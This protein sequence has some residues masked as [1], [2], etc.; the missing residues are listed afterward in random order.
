MDGKDFKILMNDLYPQMLR[1]AEMVLGDADAAAD[2]VQDVAIRLWQH[3]RDLETADNRRAYCLRSVRN[4][5]LSTM[6]TLS[7]PEPLEAAAEIA[8]SPPYSDTASA[9]LT[10]LEHLPDQQRQ[11]FMLR[12][13]DGLEF[14]TIADRMNLSSANARQLLSRARKKLQTLCKQH[15]I[16]S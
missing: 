12:Q 9:L 2:T 3:R 4:A 8:A 5:A 13:Y 14:D 15:G 7:Y 6:R 16:F 11:V 1:C 10:L